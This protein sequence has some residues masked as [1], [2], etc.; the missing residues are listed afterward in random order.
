MRLRK[1]L[2]G[3]AVALASLGG[4]AYA[5]SPIALGGSAFPLTLISTSPINLVDGFN[6]MLILINQQTVGISAVYTRAMTEPTGGADTSG[7]IF[8]TTLQ[9]NPLEQVSHTT[10]FVSTTGVNLNNTTYYTILASQSGRTIYPL[11]N[12]TIMVSGTAATATSIVLECS[13][14]NSA[15]GT[16]IATWPI[17]AL[18]TNVPVPAFTSPALSVTSG[19]P[20]VNGCPSGQGIF[21]SVVGSQIT[22]TDYVYLNLPYAIQ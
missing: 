17:S 12:T 20:M 4:V 3:L 19:T 21:M 14:T 9:Q 6:E 2:L 11:I 18:V 22:T 5:T 15:G 1:W 7:T 16:V 10:A 13:G 8:S